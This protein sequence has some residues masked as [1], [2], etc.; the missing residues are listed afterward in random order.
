[1]INR[2]HQSAHGFYS[3][4]RKKRFNDFFAISISLHNIC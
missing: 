1:M 4:L 3:D 2:T